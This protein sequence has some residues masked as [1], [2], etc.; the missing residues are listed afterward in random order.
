MSI[1]VIVA[2]ISLCLLYGSAIIGFWINIKVKLT[3]LD[4]RITNNKDDC[5][6]LD[7]KIDKML[8]DNKEEH[9][10]ILNKQDQLLVLLNKWKLEN[11]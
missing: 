1:G 6:R 8:K 5:D 4:M 2:I 11:K 3:E 7:I 9:K 10:E